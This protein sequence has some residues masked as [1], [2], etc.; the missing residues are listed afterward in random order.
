MSSALAIAAVTAI[1]KDLL[2]NGIIDGNI[3]EKTGDVSVTTLAPE[4][5]LPKKDDTSS[6]LGLF[7][8]QVT[9]NQGWRNAGLPSFDSNG[10]RVSNPPLALD[11]HYLL[12]AYGLKDYDAEILLGTAMQILHET[13]VLTRKAIQKSL[14]GYPN[15]SGSSPEQI[16]PFSG[17]DATNLARQLESIK[18]TPEPLSTDEMSKIWS[19]LQ[20]SYRPTMGYKVSVVLIEAERPTKHPLPVSSRGIYSYTFSSPVIEQLTSQDKAHDPII[21]DMPIVIGQRLVILGKGLQGEV[22]KVRISGIEV[23]PSKDDI[24]DTCIIVQIPPELMAGAQTVQVIHKKQLGNE[25]REFQTSESNGM[26]FMLR[27]SIKSIDSS[28]KTITFN[29]YVGKFQRVFL[30][31]DEYREPG[32]LSSIPLKTYSLQ[33]PKDNGI[34]NTSDEMTEKITFEGELVP[35]DYLVRVR[36]DGAESMLNS[37]TKGYYDSPRE[38][39][40]G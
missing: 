23:M 30:L 39:F 37:D 7:M 10:S 18:I 24:S 1:L 33:A 19:A 8:Y 36:V 15:L 4:L 21:K 17:S 22:T 20:K 40:N 13:P 5:I 31:L 35:G 38:S 3:A 29:H 26:A 25:K 28:S 14:S 6:Q 32:N 2:D 16:L 27:P 11:L 9:F 34:T 12:T